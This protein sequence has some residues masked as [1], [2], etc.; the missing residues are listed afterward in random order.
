MVHVALQDRLFTTT[1]VTN[2]G[3]QLCEATYTAYVSDY[4]NWWRLV[5]QGGVLGER[6][7]F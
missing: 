2:Q 6:L 3:A 1:L 5:S 7:L 4:G